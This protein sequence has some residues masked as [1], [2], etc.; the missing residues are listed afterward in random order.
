LS[1]DRPFSKS[2]QK[3]ALKKKYQLS[4]TSKAGVHQLQDK[5]KAGSD[6]SDDGELFN[7]C[8]LSNP[9]NKFIVK[10]QIN[11]V[12]VE[13]EVDSGEQRSTVPWKLFQEQLASICHLMLMLVTLRQY[14]QSPLDVKG[15][16]QAEIIINDKAFRGSFIVVDVATH[17]PLFGRDWMYLLGFNLTKLIN[18]ATASVLHAINVISAE[19]LF[20]EFADVFKDELGLLRGIEATITVDPTAM[21]KFHRHHSVPF[22]LKEKVEC[23]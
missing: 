5:D 1:E 11:G 17:Y 13:M 7:I 19:S 21:P 10:V 14:D 6:K 15:E 8:Q 3:T 18:E 20:R 2:K 12:E 22:A 4:S 16:C 23:P 9:A